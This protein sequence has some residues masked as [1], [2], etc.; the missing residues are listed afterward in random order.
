MSLL[1]LATSTVTGLLSGLVKSAFALASWVI[2]WL[3]AAELGTRLSA[4]LSW[5]QD[6]FAALACEW[7]EK[8]SGSVLAFVGKDELQLAQEFL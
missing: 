3:F 4:L 5:P 7:V 2:A 1:V 6:R 8:T